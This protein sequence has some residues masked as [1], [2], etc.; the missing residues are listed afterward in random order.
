MPDRPPLLTVGEVL[1]T[2]SAGSL[3]IFDASVWHGRPANTTGAVRLFKIGM[4]RCSPEV[5]RA[6][7]AGELHSSCPVHISGDSRHLTL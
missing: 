5:S 1:A 4:N 7:R 2:G 3:I 6:L